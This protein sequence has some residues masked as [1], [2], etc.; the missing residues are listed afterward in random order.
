MIVT[1]GQL[2][3]RAEF[4][5]QLGQ[6]TAAGLGLV[7]ALEQLKSHPPARSY[8]APIQRILDELGAGCTFTDAVQR[9]G[10]WLPQFDL[11][12]LRAG[13][14]SGRLDACF[15]LLANYYSDRARLTRQMMADLAYP[16]F[17]LHFAVFLFP[18]AQFFASGD[19]P[20]YLAKT[21]GILLPLYAIVAL[22]IYAAQS[23][24]G[25]RWRAWVESILHPVP[26]LGAARRSLALARLAA[27]LEALISAGVS[28]VE[29]WDLAAGASGSPALRR[30]VLAWKPAVLSG[31]TPAEAVR[32]SRSFPE[33]FTNFYS[34]GE[35]SGKLDESLGQLHRY[36]LEEGTRKLHLVALWTPRIIYLGIMLIIAYRILQF[37]MGYFQ[38]VQSVVGN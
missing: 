21:F 33:L 9:S 15:R 4:Y 36:F 1:P 5:H 23:G 26:V 18:F 31:Q 32:A 17:L 20:R 14:Y 6:L 11:A 16:T 30:A 37:W 12:L 10:Q 25:E 24:H 34:S 13:E 2:N 19:L 7:R 8:R 22:L 3:Q 28:I 38:Q 35:M 27:A 29:A